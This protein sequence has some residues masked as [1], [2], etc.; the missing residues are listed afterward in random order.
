M[1]KISCFN[2]SEALVTGANGFIGSHLVDSL[3]SLGCKVHCIVRKTSNLRWIQLKEVKLHFVNLSDSSFKIPELHNID[4]IFHCAGLTKSKNREEYFDI[5]ARVCETLYEQ[6]L[7]FGE[8]IKGIIHLSSLAAAG[9]SKGGVML[10]EE[11]FLTPITYYGKSKKAGEEIALKYSENLPIKILRPPVVYGP[12]EEN[13]FNF[14]KML[15]KGWALQIGET[16]K[17]LSLIYVADLIQAMLKACSKSPTKN[18]VYFITDGEFYSWEDI[19]KSATDKMRIS[20]R[21]LKIPEGVLPPIGII[22]ELL[23]VFSSKPALF[24]RQ[25]M[26]DIR[27]SS[28]TASPEKFFCDFAF[29]PKFSLTAGLA[30]TLDWYH[31]EKWL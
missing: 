6:C 28:W 30:D 19:T 8:R 2:G 4:Y 3:L 13:L 1:K 26:I 27:Q 18:K 29:N 12:R 20:A 10:D 16:P 22:F 11:S 21:I 15:K 17:K 24:D 25:R 14:F 23:A 31:R 7:Q 5:N 9:P